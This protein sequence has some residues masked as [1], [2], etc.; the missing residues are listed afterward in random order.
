[1][2]FSPVTVV[3][4]HNSGK[5]YGVIL[6]KTGTSKENTFNRVPTRSS[7]V[8]ANH[9]FSGFPPARQVKLVDEAHDAVPHESPDRCIDGVRSKTKKC[10]PETVTEFPPVPGLLIGVWWEAT[11][12]SKVKKLNLM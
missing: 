12:A 4:I 1:M 8:I 5:L 3:L 9:D 6:E 10:K 7:M 2:K 11:G